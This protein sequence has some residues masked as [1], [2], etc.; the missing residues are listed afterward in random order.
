MEPGVIKVVMS[1]GDGGALVWGLF[2]AVFMAAA[3]R[4]Q[5]KNQGIRIV[6]YLAIRAHTSGR[7]VA[8]EES[9]SMS[10]GSQPEGKSDNV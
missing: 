1:C 8:E 10:C 6:I 5:R 7:K 2:G 9:E 3:M 4:G